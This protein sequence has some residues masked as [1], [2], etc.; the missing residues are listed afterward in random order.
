MRLERLNPG[1]IVLPPGAFQVSKAVHDGKYLLFNDLAGHTVTLPA[2]VGSGADFTFIGQVSPTTNNNIV[3]V[4]NATDTM[5]GSLT[6]SGTTT[7]AFPASA[8]AGADLIT[9]N[10]TTTGGGGRGE[11]LEF[12]DVAPGLWFVKG[13]LTGVGAPATP[14]TSGV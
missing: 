7:V 8:V 1:V 2:A 14:F 11:W 6:I 13:N 3:K 9:M 5:L 10:R 4:Q 12:I